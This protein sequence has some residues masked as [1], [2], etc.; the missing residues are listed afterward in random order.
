MLGRRALGQIHLASIN[1]LDCTHV[2]YTN[3]THFLQLNVGKKTMDL[4]LSYFCLYIFCMFIIFSNF[5][6]LIL[7]DAKQPN[8][9][10]VQ[11]F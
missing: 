10:F 7:I 9:I 4:L 3:A 6:F 1:L 8:V 11:I 2:S 5:P